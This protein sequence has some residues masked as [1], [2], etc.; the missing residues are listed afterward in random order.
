MACVTDV[1][2]G[3]PYNEYTYGKVFTQCNKDISVREYIKEDQ[4]YLIALPQI[5]TFLVVLCTFVGINVCDMFIKAT[6]KNGEVYT[7]DE[8]NECIISYQY[9]NYDT[10][11]YTSYSSK[12]KCM[13]YSFA[14]Q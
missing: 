11:S 12:E 10:I 8:T 5:K 4:K 6:I 3:L 14:D 2:L 7:E 1:Q 13:L 9:S